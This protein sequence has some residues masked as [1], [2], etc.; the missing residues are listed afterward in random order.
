ML[1]GWTI[2]VT[3]ACTSESD[4]P[5]TPVLGTGYTLP[6]SRRLNP[7]TMTVAFYAYFCLACG[8]SRPVSSLVAVL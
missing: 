5:F 3:W 4:E 7:I 8:I 1:C 6:I 2:F